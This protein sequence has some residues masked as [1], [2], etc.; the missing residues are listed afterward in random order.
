MAGEQ[1]TGTNLAG[2][3]VARHRRQRSFRAWQD[4]IR[5]PSLT[6]LLILQICA[7]FL[8]APL[9]AKGL[10]IARAI[11]NTLVIA[12]LVIVVMMSPRLVAG[13]LILLGLAATAAGL[14]VS[15][16]WSPVATSVLRHGGEILTFS[17]LIWVVVH[18]VYAPGR[19]TLQR[20]QGAGVIYLSVATMFAAAYALIWE[21][22]PGAFVNLVAPSSDAKEVSTMLYFSLTTLT[23]T[24][25]GDIVAIEPFARSLANLESVLGQ[26]FLAITV[27]RLVTLEMADRRR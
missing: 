23:A 15:A 22:N 14:L 18:A 5:D 16:E 13:I 19:I 26:F 21:L 25:Y 7:I 17:A 9:A 4:R 10:P 1:I 24:G 11:A 27:A 6:A 8:A 12:V 20:L 3:S 2:A